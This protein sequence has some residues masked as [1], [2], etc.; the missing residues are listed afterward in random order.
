MGSGGGRP[1]AL[2]TAPQLWALG[3]CR[4]QGGAHARVFCGYWRGEASSSTHSAPAMGA[5][6]VQEA[7]GS[8]RACF[9]VGTGGGR[10][11]VLHTAPQL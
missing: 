5:R 2:H 7:G 11:A 1:A 8:T 3:L 10:P 4:K 9:F 6:P